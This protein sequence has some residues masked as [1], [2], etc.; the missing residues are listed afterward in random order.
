MCSISATITFLR[1]I[2][3][4]PLGNLLEEDHLVFRDK[5]SPQVFH[6]RRLVP[7]VFPPGRFRRRRGASL[8]VFHP[9]VA[10]RD[11][12]PDVRLCHRLLGR[13]PVRS[14]A[15][16][17]DAEQHVRL[18][19]PAD[20]LK[21]PTRSLSRLSAPVKSSHAPRCSFAT[22]RSAVPRSSAR[23][24]VAACASARHTSRMTSAID[25]SSSLSLPRKIVVKRRE[26]PPAQCLY[27]PAATR[28][29]VATAG[30]ESPRSGPGDFGV[31]FEVPSGV[32]SG[33]PTAEDGLEE[34]AGVPRTPRR[35]QPRDRHPPRAERGR[36]KA[37]AGL[38]HRVNRLLALTRR[39][40]HPRHAELLV[41]MFEL[42]CVAETLQG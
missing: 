36:T 30:A 10:Q 27:R 8:K 33:L 9:R 24:A 19:F 6:R 18:Q 42:E 40:E 26:N 5:F 20:R 41:E 32:P 3:L 28:R 15:M 35:R 12:L 13:A 11:G 21:S 14:G 39:A 17:A 31:P 16:G 4:G 34:D 38:V 2:S 29:V 7:R 23:R 1:Q 37:R 22:R 25:A